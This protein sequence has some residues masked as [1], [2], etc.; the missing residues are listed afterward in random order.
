MKTGKTGWLSPDGK[1]Y[2]CERMEHMDM[3]EKLVK[4]Y[5][6]KHK[7]YLTDE[8]LLDNGWVRISVATFFEHGYAVAY[9]V[10]KLTYEQL[11]FL[12]PYIYDEYSL[13]LIEKYKNELLKQLGEI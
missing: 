4:E 1:F 11:D 5:N 12:K 3:S 10:D 7:Q 9:L 8:A 2:Q 6:Y 13:P